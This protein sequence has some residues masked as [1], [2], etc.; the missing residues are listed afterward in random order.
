MKFNR[1]KVKTVAASVQKV[2]L[3][4]REDLNF[5]TALIQR[6][7]IHFKRVYFLNSEMLLK[8]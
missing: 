1:E 6:N 7:Y 4:A 5:L 3:Q 8:H 2:S